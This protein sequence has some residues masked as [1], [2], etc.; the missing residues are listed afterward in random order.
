MAEEETKQ[1]ADSA[2]FGFGGDQFNPIHVL[3]ITELAAAGLA[4][5]KSS[6]EEIKA[7]AE[8]DKE[9]GKAH[10]VYEYYKGLVECGP[11]TLEHFTAM[12]DLIAERR[13]SGKE[14]AK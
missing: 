2:A 13:D 1:A 8:K 4:F 7:R 11:R 3:V 12:C 9:D 6:L 5:I 10:D 14:E